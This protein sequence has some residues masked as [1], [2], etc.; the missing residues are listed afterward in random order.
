MS[1]VDRS[2]STWQPSRRDLLFLG[3]GG[4]IAAVPFARRTPLTLVRR[5]VLTMGTIAEFAVAHRDPRQAHAAIDQAVLA[6]HFVDETMSR[7]KASSDV[8]RANAAAAREAVP[9]GPETLQVLQAGLRWS[10]DSDG[11]FDPCL[12]RLIELWDVSHRHEP[13]ASASVVRLAHRRLYRKLD[14][15][16]YQGKA[17]VRFDDPEIGLDLGAIA[18]GYAVDRAVTALRAAGVEHALVGAGGDIYALGRSPSGEPWH[19]GIQSPDHQAQI[20]GRLYLENEAVATSGDYRQFFLHRGRRYHHLLD[21]ATAVPRTTGIRSVSVVAATCME[22]DAGA[23]AAFVCE[24]PDPVLRRHGAR[25][26]HR[27]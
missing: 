1:K 24:N 14:V 9:V 3:V 12:G 5:N 10:E 11:A 4:F 7:F 16:V 23:T 20:A 19:I 21:P 13:P 18:K 8:G 26:A 22:A 2:A 25:I 15:G 17:V 6:L 27:V